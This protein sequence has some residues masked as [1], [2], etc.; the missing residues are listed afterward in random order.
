MKYWLVSFCY[1]RRLQE[2]S[3]SI[4]SSSVAEGVKSL[5]GVF[6][7]TKIKSDVPTPLW[8]WLSDIRHL[9]ELHIAVFFCY[10]PE[11]KQADPGFWPAGVRRSVFESFPE[12]QWH[13]SA[14]VR[15]RVP[16]LLH[17]AYWA[18]SPGVRTESLTNIKALC[19]C[20]FVQCLELQGL[21]LH[22]FHTKSKETC[23]GVCVWRCV[24]VFVVNKLRTLVIQWEH[25]IEHP[26]MMATFNSTLFETWVGLEV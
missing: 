5:T 12:M 20:G 3:S 8:I 22:S 17:S 11:Q 19:W 14:S 18:A 25:S 10:T 4:N 13:T 1:T 6:F 21:T 24:Y 15:P 26:E 9:S 23:A 16:L 2:V 7:W